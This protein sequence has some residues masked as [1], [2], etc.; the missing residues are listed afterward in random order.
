MRA[1]ISKS[2]RE[3]KEFVRN[4]ERAKMVD[5][6][7]SKSAAKKRKDRAAGDSTSTSTNTSQEQEAQRAVRQFRQAAV[8]RKA[9]QKPPEEAKRVLSKLF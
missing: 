2:T 5:G 7:E 1:E 9:V 6:I 3:N 4:I 8:G